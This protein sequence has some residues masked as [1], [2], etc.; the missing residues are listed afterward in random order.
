MPSHA[1]D[2]THVPLIIGPFPPPIYGSAVIDAALA[3]RLL[4]EGYAVVCIDTAAG[5]LRTGVAYHLGRVRVFL[6]GLS[7]CL[8]SPDA[9]MRPSFLISVNGGLG[10]L[11]D[12]AFA[13]AARGRG[14][15]L[16]LYH[17]SARYIDRSSF[18]MRLLLTVAG[19]GA[20]HVACSQAMFAA[21]QE[22]YNIQDSRAFLHVSNA[23]WVAAEAPVPD[24]R[25][26]VVNLGMLSVLNSEKGLDLAMESLRHIRR[27]GIGAR[28]WL[29]GTPAGPRDEALIAAAQ[30]EFGEALIVCGA[31][32]DAGRS[33]FLAGLDVFLFPSRYRHETQ[34]LVVP[35][36][37]AAG[38]P[39]V[40]FDHRYVGEMMGGAGL[41]VN[42]E[43]DYPDA[44]LD[45]L[46]M[47]MA[48][49]TLRSGARL[50]ARRQFEQLKALA[51]D[52]LAHLVRALTQ[53]AP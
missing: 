36:A 28:L 34:S 35:E 46:R 32:D 23:A 3:A 27:A 6:R 43:A 14:A 41:M 29:A 20:V 39:V 40:A 10:I 11:Y 45:W 17:H 5:P 7:R 4:D 15:P 42:P 52:A 31:I 51:G 53:G 18:L 16:F 25:D 30:M 13:C 49:G 8:R 2:Q 1:V 37:L 24:P 21:L 19:Q 47:A 33:R 48:D 44:L 50:A 12:I 22:Q 26:A 38:V 9:R